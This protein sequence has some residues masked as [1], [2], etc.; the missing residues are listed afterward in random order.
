[1]ATSWPQA[2][3][4]SEA[5]DRRSR[6]ASSRLAPAELLQRLAEVTASNPMAKVGLM[7]VTL[8]RSD[9]LAA[10]AQAESARF[11]ISEICRR[12]SGILRPSDRYAVPAIDE[13]WVLLAD[14]PSESLIELAAHTLKDSLSRPIYAAAPGTPAP[15]PVVQVRPAIGACWSAE[16]LLPDPVILLTA[17]HD[18]CQ[19]ARRA[20]DHIVVR[21]LDSAEDLINRNALELELRKALHANELEVFLQPQIELQT[22]RC[23]GAEALVRW[24]RADGRLI[25][26][27]L[28]A[29]LCEE[30]GMMSQLTQF[31]LNTSLRHMMAWN[32]HDVDISVSVNLSAVTLADMN[33][34]AL[35]ANA[36]S[37]WNIEPRRLT[38]ELTESAIVQ[39]E[40]SA[41]EFMRQIRS[42]GCS[43]A[44]DDFGTGYSSFAYLRGFPL[45][46]LKI[47]RSFVRNLVTDAS[48]QRIVQALVDLAHTFDM[49]ALAEGVETVETA[50]ML[51]DL[52]CDIGQGY[53]FSRPMPAE[54]FLDWYRELRSDWAGRDGTA[55][56]VAPV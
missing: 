25:S 49:R 19:R 8:D 9:R 1:M 52:G 53:L 6:R 7:I 41:L 13:V 40:R 23:I 2:T 48:D 3:T 54:R 10:L 51:H 31:V 47:D 42:Y 18:A 32:S 37:T 17:S 38:L 30:R 26:P 12:V 28:I 29:E 20:D 35:V 11:V 44:L 39:H 50:E 4:S 5:A 33:F 36:L 15:V 27:S 46:E 34:P 21:K 22:S 24:R 45:D 14:L 43:L 55:E 16:Q 56:I